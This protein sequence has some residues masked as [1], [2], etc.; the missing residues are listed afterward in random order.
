RARSIIVQSE[1]ER[2]DRVNVA[3]GEPLQH[4][5]VLIRFI[6]TLIRNREVRRVDRFH[7]YEYPLAARGRDQV[8]Q[9]FVAQQV[10]AYLGDPIHLG[11]GGDDIPQ[12]RLRS[13]DVDREVV[14]DEED[15]Y[16]PALAAAPGFQAKQFLNDALVRAKPYRVTEETGHRAELA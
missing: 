5:S 11:A 13:F 14:I 6:E 2:R 10:R 8:D 1:D 4:R 15:R 7:A 3:L 12:Q 9:F 16:L